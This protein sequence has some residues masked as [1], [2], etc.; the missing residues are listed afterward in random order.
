[1]A[2][3]QESPVLPIHGSGYGL[4]SDGPGRDPVDGAWSDNWCTLMAKVGG[5]FVPVRRFQDQTA[6]VDYVQ[7]QLLAAR[8]R[9]KK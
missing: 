5:S 1:M 6:A 8:E 2:A 4:R 9:R 3:V 7:V